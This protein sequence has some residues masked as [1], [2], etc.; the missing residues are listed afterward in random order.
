MTQR[1][2]NFKRKK[3]SKNWTFFKNLLKELN[4]FLFD[5][6]QRIELFF[7]LTQRIVSFFEK[8]LEELNPLL[9]YVSM[10]WIFFM[11]QRIA[12]FFF[13][14]TYDSK[15]W[16]FFSKNLRIDPFL[17]IWLSPRIQA[18]WT[19]S[20]DSKELNFLLKMTQKFC[21]LDLTHIFDWLLEC[22]CFVYV[23]SNNW[24]VFWIRLKDWTFLID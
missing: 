9:E 8:L 17:P 1:I 3:D 11:T 4:P 16:T 20:Y 18:F 24:T 2:E 22:Y 6:T 13:E 19:F 5:V 23:D 15:N 12:T 10:N 14:E 7:S 21:S